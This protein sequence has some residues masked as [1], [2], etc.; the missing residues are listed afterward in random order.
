MFASHILRPN[1]PVSEVSKIVLTF[2]MMSEAR[3]MADEN[4]VFFSKR[5][6]VIKFP[7]NNDNVSIVHVRFHVTQVMSVQSPGTECTSIVN[8]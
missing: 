2:V 8:F 7:V 6:I 1:S 3:W 5:S 4:I